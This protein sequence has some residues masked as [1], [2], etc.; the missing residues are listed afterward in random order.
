MALSDG[1]TVHEDNLPDYVLRHS[2]GNAPDARPIN[3]TPS[4]PLPMASAAPFSVPAQPLAA[5]PAKNLDDNLA[6]YEKGILLRA[7]AEAGGVKK[8]AAELLGINYRS[9]RHRLHKYGL[10]DASPT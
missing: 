4:Q 8:R 5:T 9:F 1:E 2:N 6:A 10:N 3:G 7:L